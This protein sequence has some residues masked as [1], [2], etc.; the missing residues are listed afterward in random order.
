MAADFFD[1]TVGLDEG[2]TE[3]D[4]GITDE[5]VIEAR[6]GSADIGGAVGLCEVISD[7]WEAASDEAIA[8]APSISPSGTNQFPHK[9]LR[10]KVLLQQPV[11]SSVRSLQHTLDVNVP[12]VVGH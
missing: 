6:E 3:E 5:G 12:L 4:G 11:F 7:D 2:V 1:G 10:S 9:L 8:L